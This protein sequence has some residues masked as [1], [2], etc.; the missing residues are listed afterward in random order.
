MSILFGD[1]RA[2]LL[3]G[4]FAIHVVLPAIHLVAMRP[5]SVHSSAVEYA[6]GR[7]SL[8]TLSSRVEYPY[9]DSEAQANA[10]KPQEHAD[11]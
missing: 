2:S 1:H 4:G 5:P 8:V 10:Q 6:Q 7:V 11:F 9:G 3:L